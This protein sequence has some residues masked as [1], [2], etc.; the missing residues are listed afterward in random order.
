VFCM[1]YRPLVNLYSSPAMGDTM[2]Y[3]IS[4]GTYTYSKVTNECMLMRAGI[5]YRENV[6]GENVPC[7]CA[8]VHPPKLYVTVSILMSVI[9]TTAHESLTLTLN[10]DR[11]D[12]ATISE[13][14][15]E[16]IHT[17]HPGL[18]IEY[19]YY[20]RP[21]VDFS[22]AMPCKPQHVK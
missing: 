10:C 16:A 20:M 7:V 9:S 15:N 13:W 18:H 4:R 19:Y 3:F 6:S 14:I 1:I 2:E 11:L 22:L 8:A 17:T 21:C 12:N 5:C